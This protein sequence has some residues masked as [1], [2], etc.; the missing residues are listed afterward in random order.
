[1][2]KSI[3]EFC[4]PIAIAWLPERIS[5]LLFCCFSRCLVF[6]DVNP[7]FAAVIA[8]SDSLN[9]DLISSSSFSSGMP[10]IFVREPA[11]AMFW[12]RPSSLN[13]SPR[14]VMPFFFRACL[15]V[16]IVRSSSA[17]KMSVFDSWD[18]IGSSEIVRVLKLWPPRIKDW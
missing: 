11:S 16:L 17:T 9:W 1:M 8:L 7:F 10:R 6:W 3:F 18:S 4:A 2:Y 15:W 14:I 12:F 5:V 13:S